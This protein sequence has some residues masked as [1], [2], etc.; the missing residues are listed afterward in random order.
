M[1]G[2]E[3]TPRPVTP[4]AAAAADKHREPLH[5]LPPANHIDN[6]QEHE[7]TRRNHTNLDHE[8]LLLNRSRAAASTLMLPS[9]PPVQGGSTPTLPPPPRGPRSGTP[10]P[11]S[12]PSFLSLQFAMSVSFDPSSGKPAEWKRLQGRQLRLAMDRIEQILAG[13]SLSFPHYTNIQGT[14]NDDLLWYYES[15]SVVGA[16]VLMT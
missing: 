5:A 13:L 4:A 2:E 9:N 16:I 15:S 14:D 8:S 7:Q 11:D 6:A 3:N 10:P 12:I 1:D